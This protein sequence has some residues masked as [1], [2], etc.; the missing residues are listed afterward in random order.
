MGN[1]AERIRN[2]WSVFLNKDP[3]IERMDPFGTV[4]NYRPDRIRLSRGYDRSIINN[5]YTRIALDASAIE[6]RHVQLDKN[7]RFTSDVSSDLNYCLTMEPNK[8][9]TPRLFFQDVI[10]S[11]FD[12]GC[13][14][15]VPTHTTT[16][17]RTGSYDI[18]A[19]RTGKILE[20]A[21]SKVK[22]RVYNE[23][24]GNKEDIWLAK[25][26]VAIIENPFYSIMNEPNST[27]QR[28]IR[29]LN[30]IDTIDERS[31]GNNLDLIVQVPYSAR[32]EI[33][34]GRADSR[35]QE[36]ERQLNSSSTG[37]AYIDGSEHIIQLNRPV[38]TTMM[39]QVEYLTKSLHSQIGIT[40][41][42]LD[43]TADEKTMINYQN[44][45]IE[46]IL[47]AIVDEM[48]RKFLTKTARTQGKSIIFF[49]DPFKLVPVGE[50]AETV[51]KFTRN[52]VMSTNEFRQ[53]IGMAPVQDK[54][55]DQLRN[56]NLNPGENQ[57]FATVD[58]DSTENKGGNDANEEV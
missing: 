47:S 58:E 39:Q 49:K 55:A 31:N 37:I 56:K 32:N 41:T 3:T 42:I 17:P 28:L 1:F 53:I 54:L 14:A 26:Y 20:W 25:D 46:V 9:Q 11:M 5:I 40:E 43:G 22:V 7:K 19:L 34:K 15:I 21:P 10:M 4:T 48:K 18:Q 16:N 38:S 44:R 13:V 51:D 6:I 2:A 35:R 8:D 52:E 30:L 24:T 57:H 12:E 23:D 36:I 33:Q 27:A 45:V 29:K 50:L